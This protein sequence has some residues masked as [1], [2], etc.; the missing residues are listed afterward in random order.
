MSNILRL[1]FVRLKRVLVNAEHLCTFGTLM[2]RM[3]A[4]C[5]TICER[6]W[7]APYRH[8]LGWESGVFP[9]LFLLFAG[10]N[11]IQRWFEPLHGDV[12]KDLNGL[13]QWLMRF[14]WF[15]P[16][17]CIVG[18]PNGSMERQMLPLLIE[19]VCNIIRKLI[20]P[21]TNIVLTLD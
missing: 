19:H 10:V 15:S 11:Q 7:K 17:G 18:S 8:H 14:N 21:S 1:H 12:L 9:F 13:R 3:E 2:K 6:N 16:D 20:P 4:L 5:H